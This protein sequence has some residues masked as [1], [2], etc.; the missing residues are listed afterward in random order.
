MPSI[1]TK[2]GMRG[3]HVYYNNG[4]YSHHGIDCGDGTVIQYTKNQGNISCISWSDFA[5][6]MTVLVREYG[7]CSL[8]D[9][10]I[11]RAQSR[12]KQNAYVLFEN[13]SEN[14]ATWCKTGVYATEQVKKAKA[15]AAGVSGNRAA[16][17]GLLE[18]FG[19]VGDAAGLSRAG[20]MSGV[21]EVVGGGAVASIC[22]LD[23][24]PAVITQIAPAVITQIAMNHVLT[25]DENLLDDELTGGFFNQIVQIIPVTNV[26]G[27]TL[28]SF[29]PPTPTI[30][31]QIAMNQF[32]TND[33]LTG[34]F[35]K[36]IPQIIPVTKV[37]G[38]SLASFFPPNG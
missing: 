8:S 17:A 28:A 24:A 21:V 11:K 12:L 29:F 36:Q 3:D 2:H 30:I 13:N 1:N 37:D 5:S 32:L 35:F 22:A 31:T 25:N 20:I 23:L 18:V 27:K 14:F 16:V 26:D 38:K 19:A 33:E 10:V 9:V 6:D 34:G 15:V 4:G 7:N